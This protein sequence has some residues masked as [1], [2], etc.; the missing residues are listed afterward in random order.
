M[1]ELSLCTISF[2]HQ[3][4]SLPE[5]AQWASLNHFQ[6]IELWGAH[7]RNMHNSHSLNAQWLQRY[8]LHISMLSDY[9]PMAGKDEDASTYCHQLCR[10]AHHW[11]THK[12]RTFA[13]QQGSSSF[14]ENQ[15]DMM[16]ARL[17]LYCDILQ[18]YDCTLLIETHPNTYADCS[19]ATQKLI[20]AV[21]RQNL[22]INFDVL[23]IWEAR[24]CPLKA[25][26]QLEKHIRHMHLK[27]IRS[28]EHLAVF[29]PNNIYA[30]AGTREGIV[31]TFEGAFDYHHFLGALPKD[32]DYAMSLEWFGHPTLDTLAQDSRMIAALNHCNPRTREENTLADSA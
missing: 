31:P 15:F 1:I 25:W 5:L 17:Q 2:R 21:G 19:G 16:V 11:H 10:L 8:S 7:A 3:L 22:A 27:N 13:G 12:I 9:L 26:Q 29:E 4:I 6:G 20:D 18:A 28:R 23:H 14:S 30:A 32:R 24:E